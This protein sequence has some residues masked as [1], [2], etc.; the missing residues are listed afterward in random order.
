MDF[1]FRQNKYSFQEN[2]LKGNKY[3]REKYKKK[4]NKK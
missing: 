1:L 3:S 4:G 2:S